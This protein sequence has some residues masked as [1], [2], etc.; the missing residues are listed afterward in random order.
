MKKICIFTY[1][2]M[3]PHQTMV[4]FHIENLFSGSA[5]VCAGKETTFQPVKRTVFDRSSVSRTLWDKVLEPVTGLSNKLKGLPQK[6]LIG[7]ERAQIVDFLRRESVDAV[8]CE[9]GCIGAEVVSSIGDIGIPMFTYYRGY[10]GTMRIR[11]SRQQRLTARA[12]EKT[13]G[14]FFVSKFLQDN[15]ASYGLVHPNS[16]VI[17]SGVNTDKFQPLEKKKRKFVAI[18]RL[19]DKKRPDITVRSF[20]EEAK[21]YPDATLSLLGGGPWQERCQEIIRDMGMEDRVEILGEQSHENVLKHLQEAEFFLQHSVTSPEGDAEGAPTSIQEALACGCVVLST[22]HAG[23]PELVSEGETGF[24]VD[25][26][27]ETGFRA[28]IRDALSGKIDAEK[29]GCASREFAVRN[30]DNRLLIKRL[31]SVLSEA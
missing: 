14:L 6:S 9:F 10:D 26:L 30:L 12:F 3:H 1:A 21:S 19:V 29:I 17:P 2:Y 18:G 24:L 5:V 20:C 13:A 16:H 11:S 22:R 23:I 28:L 8:L 31:E 4:N 7:S 27:D 15:L 25:E